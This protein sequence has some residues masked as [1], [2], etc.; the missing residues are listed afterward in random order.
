MLS[1]T[2][3]GS[4]TSRL[5]NIGFFSSMS[6]KSCQYSKPTPSFSFVGRN[7]FL[8]SLQRS[9]LNLTASA[10]KS[11]PSW[12][13]TPFRRLNVQV[14]PSDEACHFSARA[15]STSVVPGLKRT[16]PSNMAW[17]TSD[18]S[19][20][21]IMAGSSLTA[22][23]DLPHANVLPPGLAAAEAEAHTAGLLAL[24]G[25]AAILTEPCALPTLGAAGA[26]PPQADNTRTKETRLPAR[27]RDR[28]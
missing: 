5:L 12:N 16:S 28:R 15:G 21:S 9:K 25:E 1:R 6:M 10:L 7:W 26:V 3:D 14:R 11:V 18:D 24:A 13:L 8:S 19:P 2:V 27:P 4:T 23:P 22:S 20:S 17:V